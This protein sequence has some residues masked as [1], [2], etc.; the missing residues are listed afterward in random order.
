[1]MLPA[2]LL[3]KIQDEYEA[4]GGKVIVTPEM[5]VEILR[6]WLEIVKSMVPGG[7]GGVI[8]AG[9]IAYMKKVCKKHGR[10][11]LLEVLK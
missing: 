8:L 5:E 3:K 1:M 2:R 6:A 10:D 11:D 9:F 4:G 7:I